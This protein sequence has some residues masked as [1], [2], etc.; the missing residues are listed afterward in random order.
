ML[1]VTKERLV[2]NHRVYEVGGVIDFLAPEAEDRLIADGLAER[3]DGVAAVEAEPEPEAEPEAVSE[4]VVQM[5][6]KGPTKAALQ[7]R[8]A[9]LGLPT[10]GN[11]AELAARIADAEAADDDGEPDDEEPPS[12]SAEVPR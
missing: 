12:L 9:E 4:T 10:S 6:A 8:C 7:A 2:V 5:P 3:T 1:I 11:K